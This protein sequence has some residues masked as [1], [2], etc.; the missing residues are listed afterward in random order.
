[1]QVP[2]RV[3]LVSALLACVVAAGTAFIT[4]RVL[5]APAQQSPSNG[6][7]APGAAAP[8]DGVA[9][10]GWGKEVEVFYPTPFAAPPN[11][12]FPDGLDGTY[13]EVV[14]QKAGSFKMRRAASGL[15]GPWI[16]KV[17]WKAEGQPAK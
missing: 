17:K 8:L 9:E 15:R 10:V 5:V 7:S 14:E 3:Y 11:L 12:T 4:V 13:C 16:A 2:W 1:M 6:V